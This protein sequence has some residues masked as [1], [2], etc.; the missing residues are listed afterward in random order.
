MRFLILTILLPLKIWDLSDSKLE[1]SQNENSGIIAENAKPVLI[2]DQFKFTE[3]PAVN[4][5][6]DV[7][8]T[9]IVEGKIWK[10]STEGEL[11]LFMDKTG[12]SDGMY[13]DKKG[14]LIT[15]A[16]EKNEIWQISPDKKVKVLLDNFEGKRFN[17]PN[18]LWIDAKGGIFFT[19]PYYQ[20]P[21]WERKKPDLSNQSV[22]YLPKGS[23]TAILLDS[24]FVRP[25]GIIGSA[26]GKNLFLADIGDKKTYKYDIGK[27][28][29]LSNRRLFTDMGSD[30]MTLDNR[31]N[32][33]LTGR[34]GITVFNPQGEK[35]E[36]IAI[37]ASTANVC[38]GGKN[39]DILFIT[40][41]KA[42]Y[43]LKMNVRGI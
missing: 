1:K 33:Y 4:K 9:D 39:R 42:V 34:G 35:I 7:F 10:Y 5:N 31:G 30:G 37:P 14:N 6:G 22:Y 11:S 3:G 18:D 15:A 43:T 21:Y 19:D 23:K 16:D 2:S 8:F 36:H 38:F 20:R 17:G 29:E 24:N 12:H 25:N 27:K 13:F 41:S 26:D 28:G 40:A 32:L